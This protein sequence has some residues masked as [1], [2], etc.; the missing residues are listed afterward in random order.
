MPVITTECYDS[1]F[2]VYPS[3]N[4]QHCNGSCLMD[5]GRTPKIP[6]PIVHAGVGMANMPDLAYSISG[7]LLPAASLVIARQWI[8][9]RGLC[10]NLMGPHAGKRSGY[11]LS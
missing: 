4:E 5:E 6:A 3:F 9:P 11:S 8:P 10:R 1:I 7:Y 2:V